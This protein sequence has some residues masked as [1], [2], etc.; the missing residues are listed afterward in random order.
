MSKAVK[1]ISYQPSKYIWWDLQKGSPVRFMEYFSRFSRTGVV[2]DATL[3]T[4]E[5]G[6]RVVECTVDNL[7]DLIQEFRARK[8]A[9]RVDHH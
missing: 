7:V 6:R 8:I 9:E 1:D 3:A 2:G 5:K 4:A